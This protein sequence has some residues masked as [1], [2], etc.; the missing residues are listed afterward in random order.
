MGIN[1][2]NIKICT[3]VDTIVN[4]NYALVHVH[5]DLLSSVFGRASWK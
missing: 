3:E 2:D 5:T 4:L 1:M